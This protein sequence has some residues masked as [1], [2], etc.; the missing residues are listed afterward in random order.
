MNLA[1]NGIK[2]LTPRCLPGKIKY[3]FYR[4]NPGLLPI[5]SRYSVNNLKFDIK[6]I[7]REFILVPANKASNNVVVIWKLYYIKVI[8]EELDR[9]RKSVV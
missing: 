7:H 1:L 6:D 2:G 3:Y 4:K 5:Q 9:D 8:K